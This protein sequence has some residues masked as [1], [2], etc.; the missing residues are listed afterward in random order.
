MFILP[1][2][3]NDAWRRCPGGFN[4]TPPLAKHYL[5]RVAR[6]KQKVSIF[7]LAK[8][9]GV[10]APTISKALSNSS[11]VSDSLRERVR[12][13]AEALGFKPTRPR[14]RTFNICALVDME[15]H[16]RFRI[17]GY[18]EAVIEGIYKFCD[19]REAEFSLYV[20][21]TERLASENLTRV[22]H[23]RN[24]DGAVVI[25]ASPARSYFG[26]L[27]QNRFPFVCIF[28]GP[29]DRV[30]KVDNF[31]AGRLALDH[32]HD[33]GHRRIAIARQ[34]ARRAAARDRFS[35]FI[36]RAGERGLADDGI[37]ELVPASPY[38]AFEWGRSLIADWLEAD[39]PWTAVFCLAENVALGVLAEAALRGIRIPEE[40]SV[41]G[42]DDLI[43]ARRSAPP[44][45]V[46]DIPNVEVGYRA[47]AAV[48]RALT[49]DR[50]SR[51]LGENSVL[52]VERIV[53][54][55]STGAPAGFSA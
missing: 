38:S 20:Q 25:G 45:S 6:P 1:R 14:R 18:E 42:C 37:H 7:S 34:S 11:E 23:Q 16:N 2:A 43:S 36:R 26:N 40:L 10:S 46:V 5:K 29:E 22:L 8:E 12:A 35:S 21:T 53:A 3:Q 4:L 15:F 31:N 41:L 13:R 24:A 48:S 19:E 27:R 54:R 47:A 44:L 55:E 17:S 9:F 32:L 30:L 39:R 28:D 51:T 50:G 33:L 52:P 49:E